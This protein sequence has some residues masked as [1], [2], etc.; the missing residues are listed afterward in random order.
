M[1]SLKLFGKDDGLEW[2]ATMRN[3]GKLKILKRQN[4]KSPCLDQQHGIW[5]DEKKAVDP[6]AF[7][8]PPLGGGAG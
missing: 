4:F 5:E 7:I 8:K 2:F 6:S 1:T 3:Y